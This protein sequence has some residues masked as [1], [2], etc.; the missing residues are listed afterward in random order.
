MHD[1]CAPLITSFRDRKDE[2][3]TMTNNVHIEEA[4]LTEQCVLAM[5]TS[6][7]R[8]TWQVA[9]TIPWNVLAILPFR[10]QVRLFVGDCNQG[11][12]DLEMFLSDK[13]QQAIDAGFIRVFRCQVPG[14]NA[15]TCKNA[16][17]F[18]AV[19]A[20]RAEGFDDTQ[21]LLCN[22]DGDRFLG[23][24]FAS[25]LLRELGA[26]PA[27][28][29]LASTADEGSAG[30][31]ATR[32]DAFL[33]VGGYD[34]SL[35]YPSGCQ[36]FDLVFRL[37]RTGV[38]KVTIRDGHVIGWGLA[39][40][41]VLS[42]GRRASIVAKVANVEARF[43]GVKWGRMDQCNR[44]HMWD[45]LKAGRFRANQQEGWRP[46]HMDEVLRRA[47]ATPPAPKKMPAR[48][49][50]EGRRHDPADSSAAPPPAPTPSSSAT[51]PTPGPLSTIRTIPLK[52]C[53]LT[54]V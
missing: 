32:A 29:R 50:G 21:I 48:R 53:R 11:E 23:H 6:S 12:S 17:H 41:G 40:D 25:T 31:V 10:G 37:E 15:S 20:L 38:P 42:A 51:A 36:D 22:L 46:I 54:H 28:V 19:A 16:I 27:V 34:E 13:C 26:R 5:C 2:L 52:A 44:Q 49:P 18:A 30:I 33:N 24:G 39:N 43:A 3:Q 4:G 47:E 35:P 14:W 45:N 7:F 1:L 8:R 9:L